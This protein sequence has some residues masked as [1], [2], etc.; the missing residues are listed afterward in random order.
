[1]EALLECWSVV[2]SHSVV[3]NPL[4]THGLQHTR[5]PC[6][7]LSPKICSNSSPL[8]WWCCPTISSSV[9]PF[10]SCPQS[11][12]ASGSFSMNQLFA[13]GGQSIGNLASVL[14]VNIQSWFLLGLTGLISFL[15][16]GLSTVFSTVWKYQFFDTQPS[17]WSKAM[18]TV[19]K[20]V[21]INFFK[22]SGN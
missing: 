7:S 1:M 22:N 17:S 9:N 12:P 3:S 18:R 5:L 8:T 4:W 10:S 2:F 6:P 11:F 15:S 13:S 19:L 20:T 16:K 14:P 21:K